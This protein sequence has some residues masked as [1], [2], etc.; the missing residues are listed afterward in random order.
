[1]PISIP[2]QDSSPSSSDSAKKIAIPVGTVV[3]TITVGG[4]TY[5]L[6]KKR[7]NKQNQQPTNIQNNDNQSFE[8]AGASQPT[9]RSGDFG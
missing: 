5:Y 9:V 4:I 3:G 2:E 8:L 6:Y 1:M 7:K